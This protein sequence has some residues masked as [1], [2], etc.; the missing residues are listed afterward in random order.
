MTSAPGSPHLR[1]RL[2]DDDVVVA[3]GRLA[4]PGHLTVP[5]GP[6]GLVLFAHGSGSSRRSP[7]NEFVADWFD[8]AG[9]ATLRFD[10][11]SDDEARDRL[12]V[13][14]AELLAVRLLGATRWVREHPAWSDQPI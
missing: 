6:R 5:E 3:G 4:A 12:N 1:G 10:L 7:R 13:F 11:L 9:L 8:A 2:V 14:D